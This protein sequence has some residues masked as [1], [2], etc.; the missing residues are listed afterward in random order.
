MMDTAHKTAYMEND[1]VF[2]LLVKLALPAVVGM[3][4]NALYNVVDTIFVGQGV[5]PLAIAAVSIV[6]PIQTIVSA[7]AQAI[8]VGTASIISR[9]LGEKRPGEAEKALGTALTAVTIITAVLVAALFLFMHPILAFFGASEATMP[10]AEQYAGIVGAGFFFFSLSMC[11]SNLLRAE[12]NTRAAMFGMVI[13]AILN[14]ALDPLFIF[15]FHTGVA[16]AAI[17]TVISQFASCVYLFGMYA[18]RKTIVPVR[19][20]NLR[21]RPAILRQSFTLGVPSFVQSAGLG[22]LVLLINTTLG[23][24]GGDEAITIYGMIQKLNMIVIMPII[25]IAQGFQPIAGYNY[26]ARRFDRVRKSLWTALA[27]AFCI[28]L[29]GYSFMELLPRVAIGFFT[30]DAALLAS[31]SR[32]LRILVLLVPAAA[33]QITGS[34]YFQSVGKPTEALV[35][36]LTRQ[37]LFLIPLV[38]GLASLFGVDGVWWA[39]PAADLLAMSVTATLLLRE[40]KRLG[41]A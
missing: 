34:T 23:K 24:Y 35:L 2:P 4:V 3:M 27:T 29:F 11:A 5:G 16:G 37:F 28:S 25:G 10:Y 1:A 31:A 12:G 21:V 39:F 6:F 8:G 33:I 19:R 13:G 14:T 18:R 32:V 40:V 36:S 9:R 17:A 30:R 41:R 22:V 7:L 15:G 26:G 38:L 20:E